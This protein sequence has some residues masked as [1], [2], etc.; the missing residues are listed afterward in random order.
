[1]IQKR[2]QTVLDRRQRDRLR[3]RGEILNAA[4]SVFAA[5]GFHEAAIGDIARE[6]GYAVGTLYLHFSC[7]DSLYVSVFAERIAEMLAHVKARAKRIAA[8]REALAEAI[9]A[10]LEFRDQHRAFFDLFVR[11]EPPAGAARTR[12]WKRVP[13][14]H[15]RHAALLSRLIAKAQRRGEL[16]PLNPDKL[17]LALLGMVI[18]LARSASKEGTG[19]PMPPLAELVLDL[20]FHGAATQKGKR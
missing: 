14:C 2:S 5:R 4:E 19:E 8:P 16:R 18:H 7:K 6:A 15:R 20:F 12:E 3:A 17:A 1:V 9:R 11:G 10:Q 13:Q